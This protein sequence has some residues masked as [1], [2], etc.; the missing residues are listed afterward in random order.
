[1]ADPEKTIQKLISALNKTP[2]NMRG[3]SRSMRTLYAEKAMS[4]ISSTGLRFNELRDQTRRDAM[5]YLRG[6]LP[7][8]VTVVRSI[9]E[10][11]DYYEALNFSDWIENMGD[12]KNE[13]RGNKQCCEVVL[14][15]HDT[16][17]MSLK[18]RE[19]QVNIILDEY[20]KQSEMQNFHLKGSDFLEKLGITST[21]MRKFGKY[22]ALFCI[23]YVVLSDVTSSNSRSLLALGA[24]GLVLIEWLIASKVFSIELLGEKSKRVHEARDSKFSVNTG[25]LRIVTDTTVPALAKFMDGLQETAAFF[26]DI[27]KDLEY[28]QIDSTSTIR[29]EMKFHYEMM[30][31]NGPEV[32]ANCNTFFAVLPDVESD[33]LAIA[34]EGVDNYYVDKWLEEQK[35][36][37]FRKYQSSTPHLKRMMSNFTSEAASK[38]MVDKD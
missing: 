12:I 25:A 6:I 1:M 26:S 36:N 18:D 33:F 21:W 30:K 14:Q 24:N 11:F 15:L 34:D 31:K 28:L 4:S 22:C 3:F 7:F 27:E 23:N 10:F 19:R 2:T 5:I 17:K 29:N 8:A 13:V 9:S 37:F 16:I 20:G 35:K 32:K 38:L